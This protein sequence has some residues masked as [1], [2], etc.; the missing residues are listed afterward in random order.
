MGDKI[1]VFVQF[2]PVL[3][4]FIKLIASKCT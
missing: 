3:S 1:V 4:H 2:D